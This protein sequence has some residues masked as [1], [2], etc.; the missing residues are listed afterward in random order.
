M[1]KRAL[2]II[3]ASAALALLSPV[4]FIVARKVKKNLGSPRAVPPGAPGL[5]RQA[6]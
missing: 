4:Y 3:I 2:D 6:F 5:K 1:L